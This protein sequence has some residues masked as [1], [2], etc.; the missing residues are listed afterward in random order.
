MCV[1]LKYDAYSNSMDKE[2]NYGRPSTA[3]S[4]AYTEDNNKSR[5]PTF[6]RERENCSCGQNINLTS[7][8]LL[9]FL[10]SQ[11]IS[12]TVKWV[13]SLDLWSTDKAPYNTVQYTFLRLVAD[14]LTPSWFILQPQPWMSSHNS[15]GEKVIHCIQTAAK[16]QRLVSMWFL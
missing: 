2:N 7:F 1:C 13:H 15:P 6:M 3:G 14:A 12:T 8:K 16:R 11:T 4:W 9:L 10:F 5:W